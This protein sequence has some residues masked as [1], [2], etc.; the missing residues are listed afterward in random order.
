MVSAFTSLIFFIIIATTAMSIVAYA[1]Y[2][3][4]QAK[5]IRLQLQRLKFKTEELENVALSLDSI[6]ENRHIAK[7]VNDE[8]VDRYEYMLELDPKATFLKPGYNNAKMRQEEL[9]RESSTRKVTSLCESDSQIARYHAYL[10]E[11]VNVIRKQHSKNRIS[12]TEMGALIDQLR[13]SSLMIDVISNI[14]QGHKAYVNQD[15]LSA[16]SFY[17]IAQSE[18]MRSS[19][20]DPRRQEMIRQLADVLFGRRRALDTNLMPDDQYN[21]PPVDAGSANERDQMNAEGTA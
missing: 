21:P 16:N 6:C 18:L 2:K 3:T 19:H 4:Q 8:V 5:K 11:G 20:P 1:N 15:I 17:K 9:S 7:L 10:N 13:W 14:A 12:T